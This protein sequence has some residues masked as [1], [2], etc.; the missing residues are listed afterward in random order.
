MLAVLGDV[1]DAVPDRLG[2]GLRPDLLAV[3]E[4]RAAR[5]PA[6]G[7][8]EDAHGELGAAGPH[9]A[10]DA[11]DLAAPDRERHA[12]DHLALLVDRV[13]HGP[14]T[15]LQG[16]GGALLRAVRGAFGEA[17]VEVAADHAADDP[18][19]GRVRGPHVECLDGAP[20]TDD[21]HRV[22]DPADLAQLVGDDDR[23]DALLLQLQDEIEEFAA[24]L[25][26]EGRRRLVQDE[27]PHL[28][29][30]RLGDLHELLLAHA[31]VGDAGLRMVGQTD[32]A[33]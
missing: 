32:P 25:V 12:V 14:V 23:G 26:V 3:L 6:V 7:P 17:V 20:V 19:L 5:V 2:D 16:R 31:D 11:D 28:L 8:P 33:Q 9:E 15:D 27:Q 13:A 1:G 29:R 21:R 30:Q 4:D 10:R 18:V 24:V 22:G